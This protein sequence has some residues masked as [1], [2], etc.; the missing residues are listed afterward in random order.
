MRLFRRDTFRVKDV[1]LNL[2]IYLKGGNE[3]IKRVVKALIV[4]VFVMALNT[5][6]FASALTDFQ[7]AQAQVANLT[8]QAEQAAVLAQT[9]P[10]QAQNYQVLQTQLAQAQQRMQALQAAAAQELQQQQAVAAAQQ[11]QAQQAALQAQQAA[12]VK[13]QVSQQTVI[14][15][16]K[17]QSSSDPIVYIAATGDGDCYHHSGCRTIKYG[18]IGI[19]LSQAQ[20]MGRRPCGICY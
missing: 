14:Q 3:M 20:A 17:P 15:A 19:P 18:E 7:A 5:V 12:A 9:D 2:S 10:A 4:G 13:T 6:C 16:Q 11:Q 1:T 8:A